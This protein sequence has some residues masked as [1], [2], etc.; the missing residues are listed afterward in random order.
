MFLMMVL[1]MPYSRAIKNKKG[2]AMRKIILLMLASLCCNVFAQ[3]SLNNYPNQRITMVVPAGAGGIT[4]NL[5]RILGE[6]LTTI[7][8]QPVIIDNKP[9]ASGII[10]SGLVARSKPDGYT[11]LMSFPAHVINPSLKKDMPYNT[12]KDFAAIAKVGTVSQ[13]LLVNQEN[14]AKSLQE[15]VQ[16][17]KSKPGDLNYGSVGLGSMGN[18]SMLLFEA[19]AGLDLTHITYKGDPEVMTAL[20]SGDIQ[21]AFVSPISSMAFIKSGKVKALAIADPERLPVLPTIPTISESGYPGF[22][23]SGWNAIFAPAG[24]PKEVIKKLNTAINQALKDP[25]LQKKF[26]DQGVKPLGGTPE[27]LQESLE[28]DIL[29]TG[30]ALKAAGV[31][32]T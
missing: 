30:S 21:A 23:A 20:I 3:D 2:R 19:K 9:G 7:L 10:G 6:Q 22:S 32:P 24:T 12:A 8:R 17:A 29:N 11:I 26:L 31:N 18:L 14:K 15:F 28:Q 5:A 4:D 27:A 13:I 1:R 16:L 25:G